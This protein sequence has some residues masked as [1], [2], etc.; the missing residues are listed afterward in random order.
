MKIHAVIWDLGGVL[1]RTEDL[2][3]RQRLADRLKIPRL[4]LEQVVFSGESGRRAQR[5]EIS[6]IQ[7]WENIQQLFNLQVA[8]MQDFQRDFWGGDRVDYALIEEIRSLQGLSYKTG[9]LS[10]A[11][12]DLREAVTRD[13]KIADAFDEMVISA[14]VKMVKPDE[15]IYRYTLDRFGVSA[16]MAVFIDDMPENVEGA[17]RT[18]MH[19]IQFQSRSQVME[20]LF[21]LLDGKAL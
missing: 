4:E 7:H 5:G 8:E 13:W 12:S 16:G 18:G 19:A 9:I 15:N 2:I 6:S 1:V 11:F 20:T 10:N 3:P 21:T 14:E 17:R